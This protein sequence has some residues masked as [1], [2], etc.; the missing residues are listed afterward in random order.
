MAPPAPLKPKP[1]SQTFFTGRAS[2][3]DTLLKLEDTI[4]EA[5]YSLGRARLLPSNG[6]GEKGRGRLVVGGAQWKTAEDMAKLFD[7][8]KKLPT[9]DHRRVLVLLAQLNEYRSLIQQALSNPRTAS[10]LLNPQ[11]ISPLSRVFDVPETRKEPTHP[12]E[13]Y[14]ELDKL[15]NP[16][17][18]A[19]FTSNLARQQ[20]EAAS[21]AEAGDEEATVLKPVGSRAQGSKAYIDEL[22]RAYALGKRKESSARV[23]LVPA[24]VPRFR[25]EVTKVQDGASPEV[26]NKAAVDSP[27]HARFLEAMQSSF[28]SPTG[29]STSALA[30]APSPTGITLT[31]SISHI[32]VNNTPLHLYFANP[33][34]R[35]KIVFPFKATGTVGKFN[36]FALVRGGGTTGQAGAVAVG[37]ARAVRTLFP[38]GTKIL[39]GCESNLPNFGIG[40]HLLTPYTRRQ[41]VTS[42][43]EDG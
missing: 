28:Q 22:G 6:N 8:A 26:V 9:G 20:A 17:Q 35:E 4:K 36:V 37:I 38:A 12:L 34:D 18:R 31:P 11:P 42:R 19:S 15:L 7:S 14:D 29:T 30:P 3:K 25:E 39:K 43:S 13:I 33:I 32:L 27:A 2:F 23:W 40:D 1:T 5:K 41:S 24:K 16:F 10:T 21:R